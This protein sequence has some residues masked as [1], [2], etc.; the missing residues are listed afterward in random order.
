MAFLWIL[1]ERF[2]LYYI[3]RKA[4]YVNTAVSF[5]SNIIFLLASYFD[6]IIRKENLYFGSPQIISE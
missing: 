5:K 4:L 2:S 3:E 1:C 6:P